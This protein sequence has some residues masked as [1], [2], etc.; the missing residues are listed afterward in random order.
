MN[1]CRRTP[2]M[3]RCVM[4]QADAFCASH[5]A[6]KDKSSDEIAEH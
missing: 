2:P 5:S 4:Q 6:R 1:V 3:G